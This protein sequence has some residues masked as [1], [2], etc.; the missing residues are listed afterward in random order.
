MTIPSGAVKWSDIYSV[1]NGTLHNGS[2]SVSIGQFVGQ[3][4]SDNT[5]V[6]SNNISIGSHFRGKSM[7]SGVPPDYPPDAKQ[8][9]RGD[10]ILLNSDND[11]KNFFIPDD[12]K[13]Q[14]TADYFEFADANISSNYP[15]KADYYLTFYS[16]VGLTF[17]IYS[18][19]SLQTSIGFKFEDFDFSAYDLLGFQ[20]S[21]KPVPEGQE[22]TLQNY[23]TGTA[24][25]KVAPSVPWLQ[26]MSTTRPDWGTSFA[27][28]RYN[29]EKSKNGW[30]FPSTET[31]ARLLN[32]TQPE[33]LGVGYRVIRFYFRSDG[34][35]EYKGWRFRVIPYLPDDEEA[36]RPGED[37]P[38]FPPE[39]GPIR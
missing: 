2:T 5:F 33:K 28:G 25:P 8:I 14:T 20:V 4:W 36:G 22:G 13:R 39:E 31:K 11:T 35:S 26:K 12:W 1:V 34:S 15:R 10:I 3:Q 18:G 32:G 24:I 21:D 6:P 23:Q 7:P 38:K 37:P 29:S 9:E 27:G 30:V 17:E 16:P 19:S